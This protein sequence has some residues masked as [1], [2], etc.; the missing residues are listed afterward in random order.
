VIVDFGFVII[1][2]D[3]LVV[4]EDVSS[5]ETGIVRFEAFCNSLITFFGFR[6]DYK[7]ENGMIKRNRKN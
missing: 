1:I 5:V 6:I 3:F 4:C 2:G 7:M